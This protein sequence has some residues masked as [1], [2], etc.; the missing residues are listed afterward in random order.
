METRPQQFR[1][2]DFGAPRRGLRRFWTRH[3]RYDSVNP[4]RSITLIT[5]G[6][7]IEKTYDERTGALVNRR[8][9]VQRMLRRLRLEGTGV[10]IVDLMSKDSLEM[11]EA[12]RL[13]ILE[14]VRATLGGC[15]IRSS[16]PAAASTPARWPISA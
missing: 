15:R 3:A 8:T 4:V 13:K 10:A 9:I 14:V 11:T 6:G 7:T 12:D 2:G 5:T 1:I 16:P